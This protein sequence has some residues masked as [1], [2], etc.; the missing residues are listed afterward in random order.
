MATQ[1]Y[2]LSTSYEGMNPTEELTTRIKTSDFPSEDITLGELSDVHRMCQEVAQ[3]HENSF[4]DREDEG[5]PLSKIE[6]AFEFGEII[7]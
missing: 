7:K 5:R 4:K 1:T 3:N 2:I 6:T